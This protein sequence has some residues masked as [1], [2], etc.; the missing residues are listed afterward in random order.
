M[1]ET[2]RL[3]VGEATLKLR[4]LTDEAPNTCRAFLESLPVDSAAI[5]AKFAGDEFYF[6]I[7]R[8]VDPENSVSRVEPGDVVYYPDRQTVCIFYGDIVPFAQAGL[9]ARVEEG[10]EQ[11][12]AVGPRIWN[13]G[14]FPVHV[15]GGAQ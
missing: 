14:L 9:I 10:L 12:K 6:M 3:T 15:E 11:L 7:P 4:L 2:V 8:L 1:T 13:G 5:H